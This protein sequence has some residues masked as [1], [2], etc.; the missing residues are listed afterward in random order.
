MTYRGAVGARHL[1]FS[2]RVRASAALTACSAFAL[3]GCT[4]DPAPERPSVTPQSAYIAIVQ[5]EVDNTKPV[6]DEEG[7]AELPVIYLATTS[8]GTV[9]VAVQAEVVATIADTAVIRFADDPLEG[10]DQ[11]LEGEPVKDDGVMLVLDPF[12]P[13]QPV[14]GATISRYKSIDDV[15]TWHL[16]ITATESS[17]EVTSAV[18]ADDP[19]AG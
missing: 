7:N 2:T 11:G 16:E 12:E 3:I 13:D 10:R 19:T 6:L 5:W 9:D 8:G 17:A 15:V 1:N 18:Q 14:V 4:S